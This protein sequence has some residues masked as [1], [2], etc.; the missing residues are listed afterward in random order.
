MATSV[1]YASDAFGLMQFFPDSHTEAINDSLPNTTTVQN[2]SANGTGAEG[3]GTGDMNSGTLTNTPASGDLLIAVIMRAD[4]QAVTAAPSGWA[5]L[6]AGATAGSRSLEVW[7]ARSTGV[8]GDKGPFYFD[9]ASGT[10]AWCIE[11]YSIGGPA[12]C[13]DPAVGSAAAAF[14]SATTVTQTAAMGG[15]A[16]GPG[17]VL[18]AFC[19]GGGTISSISGAF[20]GTGTQESHTTYSNATY[21]RGGVSLVDLYNNVDYTAVPTY[22]TAWSWTTSRAGHSCAIELRA[23]GAQYGFSGDRLTAGIGST[24][25][26]YEN[27]MCQS[28]VAFDT[29]S[30]PDSNT[31]SSATIKATGSASAFAT[32]IGSIAFGDPANATLQFR[33]HGTSL[34]TNTRGNNN[35]TPYLTKAGFAGKTLAA[36]FPAAST[37]STTGENTLTS[38]A[39]LPGLINKTGT[40]A[41]V[42]S[43][44]EY[45]TGNA[46]SGAQAYA[47]RDAPTY[48]TLTV[49][50]SFIG[51][52]TVAASLTATPAIAR[53]LTFARSIAASLTVTPGIA[54]VLSFARTVSSSVT[55]SPTISQITS[56]LRTISSDLTVT[57]VLTAARSFLRTI[58][59]TIDLTSTILATKIPFVSQVARVIRLGARS[60]IQIAQT[61]TARIGGR[62]TIRTPKE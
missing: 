48:T 59:T 9:R 27:A 50:H 54:Q 30:I 19:V 24:D 35:N 37:W 51:S 15:T 22:G 7:W 34:P 14:T 20:S 2:V 46:Q 4:G 43:T 45:A 39:A 49:V 55:T 3:G 29:S 13:S 23:G 25:S 53:V 44:D 62:Y 57:P 12:A 58:A 31:I 52:A 47:M 32:G 40:T 28:F 36:T 11:L 41:F 60:T 10:A 21:T 18:T 38:D 1:F 6:T 16:D 8:V 17:M 42:V 61:V 26:G 33:Y 56:Y 5:L